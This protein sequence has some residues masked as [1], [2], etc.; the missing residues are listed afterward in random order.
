MSV[1]A[2]PVVGIVGSAG[3]YGRWL[4]R[5]FAAVM[6]LEVVGHD[7][8]DPGSATPQ[9]VLERADVLVFSAPIRH[10]P[11]IIAQWVGWAGGR[12]AGQLWL[13]VTS[14][15]AAPVA[16]L[17]GSCAEV[18]GLHPMCAPPKTP[19]LKGRAMVVCPARLQRWRGWVDTLCAALQARC[20]Q[21]EPSH[22]DRVMALVQALVHAASLAQ[23]GVLRGQ[24]GALGGL[25]AVMPFATV[26]FELDM[27][28]IARIL[29]LN[30]AIYEDIQFG[31]PYVAEVL[32][33]F[34]ARLQRLHAL[35]SRGDEAARAS[36]R[37]EF[38]AASAAAFGP[39]RLAEG[40]HGFERLGYL[41]ADLAG[42][43]AVNVH[44]PV[45]RPGSLRSLL[46]VF[47]QAQVNLSSI[48]SSRTPDGALH[49]RLGLDTGTD[50]QALAQALVQVRRRGIGQIVQ[51]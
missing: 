4:S 9:Q 10:T 27:A 43:R 36:F 2:Q 50:P 16:A 26:G 41:L 28:A 49:F 23:A 33:Q 45:D 37:D 5:F 44:L 35:V 46:E 31:N 11:A 34:S 12:E 21:A 19:S 25:E 17:L 24:A 39:R 42:E 8:A 51:A 32:G 20:V 14:V 47:E 13:D 6:G 29:A 15:K 7:P 38:L 40:N 48:H 3:A 22:H 1:P 18:V 30:P